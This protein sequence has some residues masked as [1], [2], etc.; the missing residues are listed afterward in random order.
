MRRAVNPRACKGIAEIF[1]VYLSHLFSGRLGAVPAVKGGFILR[2]AF[3][4]ICEH[5]REIAVVRVPTFPRAALVRALRF[6]I[7]VVDLVVQ[8]PALGE[9]GHRLAAAR[10]P[11]VAAPTLLAIAAR[12]PA[13]FILDVLVV[14]SLLRLTRGLVDG[15]WDVA[16]ACEYVRATRVALADV[17][18]GTL[19]P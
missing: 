5:A 2:L 13:I 7:C 10:L 3:G 11:T 8:S 1:Q 4:V 18:V 19:L 6:L 17:D 12:F 16:T 14:A 9:R 15:V